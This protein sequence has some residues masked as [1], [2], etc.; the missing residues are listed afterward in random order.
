MQMLESWFTFTKKEAY[1]TKKVY[2]QLNSQCI[3]EIANS[4][5][6]SEQVY[7]QAKERML[8]PIM[9]NNT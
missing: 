8:E 9:N 5:T 2:T 7:E 3:K 4:T 1:K 6:D